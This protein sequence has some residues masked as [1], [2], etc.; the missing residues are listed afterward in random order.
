[1][2]DN[3]ILFLVSF[4]FIWMGSGWI[5]ASADKLS[6]K[7]K[8]SSFAVS[9]FILGLLTSIPEFALGITAVNNNDPEIFVGN[10]LG[11]IVVMFLFVIPMLAVF[12]KEIKLS[13]DLDRKRI[14][15]A[16]AVIVLPSVFI[17]DQKISQVEAVIMIGAYFIAL[18]IIQAKK[19]IFSESSANAIANKSYS[20]LDLMKVL[21]GILIVFLS[22]HMI[23]DKTLYFSEI[24]NVSSFYIGLIVLSVGTNL[25][26]LSIALRSVIHGKKDVAFGDYLGSACANV[27]LMGALTLLYKGTV[28]AV[29]HFHIVFLF[30]AIGLTLFYFFARSEKKIT[31]GEGLI[32]I[33]IYALFLT[34]EFI[35]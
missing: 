13:H 19:G 26:E 8:L 6:K 30:T 5:V 31:R 35:L 17:L 34:A 14:L 28:T 2:L 21:A 10:L 16:L 9:F 32:L 24:L 7:M 11:G 33:L 12:G 23:V 22:S 18:I 20:F 25:P 27:L 29:N 1:M 3:I 4:F 15:T